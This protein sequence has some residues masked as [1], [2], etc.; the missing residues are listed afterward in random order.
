M[1]GLTSVLQAPAAAG[2]QALPG[3]E[4]EPQ[5]E[6]SGGGGLGWVLSC[7]LWVLRFGFRV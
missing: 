3:P 5:P 1:E 4:K 2:A 6:G 7:G